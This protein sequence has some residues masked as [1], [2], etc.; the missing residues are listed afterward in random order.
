MNLR[1]FSYIFVLVGVCLPG[2]RVHRQASFN[3][4]LQ[5]NTT[6]VSHTAQSREDTGSV[7]SVTT[8]SNSGSEWKY[9]ETYY[10]PAPEDSIPK[11]KSR[12]WSG[13][14]SASETNNFL[15]GNTATKTTI[16]SADTTGRQTFASVQ[17]VTEKEVAPSLSGAFLKIALIMMSLAIAIRYLFKDKSSK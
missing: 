15:Q 6:Q 7:V 17:S 4:G 12:S 3:S 14:R 16:Q 11:L 13:K 10:P 1:V 8:G 5:E 9:T 2:C